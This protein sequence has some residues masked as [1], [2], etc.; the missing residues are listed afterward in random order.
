MSMA[1]PREVLDFWFGAGPDKWFA[2]DE[3][4]DAEIRRRF[5]AAHAAAAGGQFD[6]WMSEA[7]GALALIIVLDQFSRNLH[8][9][10][11]RA[12]MQDAMSKCR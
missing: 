1:R 9:G 3:A 2:K 10:D 4:F 11:H 12:F 6:G 5:G 8:R 7:P